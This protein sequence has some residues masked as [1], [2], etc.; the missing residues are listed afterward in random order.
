MKFRLFGVIHV[1]VI[2]SADAFST[3]ISSRSFCAGQTRFRSI[4]PTTHMN[5]SSSDDN[6]DDAFMASLNSRIMQVQNQETIS[7][8]VV[9]DSMLPRQVIRILVEN[10][11]LIELVRTRIKKETP[12]F[13]MLGMELLDNGEKVDLTSGVEVEIIEKPIFVD[14][15]VLLVLK[16]GRRFVIKGEIDTVKEGWTEARVKYLISK[17]QEEKE[18]QD[19]DEMSVARAIMKAKELT[20]PTTI[21]GDNNSLVDVWVKLAKEHEREPGQIDELLEDLGD[22]PSEDEPSE[23]AFW[24]GALINPLPSIGVAMEVRPALLAAPTAE[25]RVEIAFSGIL[26]SIWYMDDSGP[27]S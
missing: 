8:L 4:E 2:A 11:I 14:G 3:S 1:I 5:L 21:M 27:M 25:E 22:I 24:V 18:A 16:A 6:L 23:R 19:E 15:G 7:P 9:L 20:S 10:P 26:E 17:E 12:T 13:G